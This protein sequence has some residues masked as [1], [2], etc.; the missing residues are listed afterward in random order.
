MN[1]TLN[2]IDEH[3]T[4]MHT[5]RHSIVGADRRGYNDSSSEYSTHV[6]HRLSYINGQETDEEE[7]QNQHTRKE[8]MSWSPDRVAEYLEEVGVEKKHCDIFREQEISGEVL[9]VMEQDTL[10]LKEL[11]LGPVGRRLRTWH[12]IKALQQDLR[13]PTSMPRS[14]SDFS[15]AG[16]GSND[17]TRNRGSSFGT[18]L[19]RIPSL[20]GVHGSSSMGRSLPQRASTQIP[21]VKEEHTLPLATTASRPPLEDPRPS[22]ASVRS[23]NHSRRHSSFEYVGSISSSAF[24]EAGKSLSPSQASHKKQPSF[25]RGWTMVGS[26]TQ[27]NGQPA[28]T[29]DDASLGLDTTMPDSNPR[30][31]D[32]TVVNALE[33]DRG[34][35]SGGE[36]ENRKSRQLLRKKDS[37]H[38]SAH[39][40]ISTEVKR[41]TAI[42]SRAS[43]P[44]SSGSIRD[45]MGPVVSPAAKA[46]Y[47]TS[48]KKD[49]RT[50]SGPEFG[51]KL[52]TAAELSPTVTKLDY[53]DSPS[54][55]TI[56]LSPSVAGSDTSS[57]GLNSPVMQKTPKSI[58]PLTS[59]SFG[60]RAISDAIT[61]NEKSLA[62]QTGDA[63][64]PQSKDSPLQSPGSSTPSATSKSFEGDSN[65][66]KT[67]TSA[68][69]TI[70]SNGTTRR[71]SK[72]H[73]SAYTRGL[74]KRSPAEQMVGCDYSGWMKKRSSN[75]MTTWKTRLFVLRG[76]RLSYYY[77]EKDTEERGLIDISS[78]RVLPAD[79]ERITG[80]HASL[81][82]AAS[83]PTSPQYT[84]GPAIANSFIAAIAPDP[85]PNDT[86]IFI[87]KLVP[88]RSGLSKAVNFTKPTVH[89][90]AVDNVQQGRL[91]MA[92]LMKATIDRD[93][94]TPVVTTYQQKTIS[95]AKA[96]AT[97]Q[98][99]P[100]LMNVDEEANQA[101]DGEVKD[102]T[103]LAISGLSNSAPP[104]SHNDPTGERENGVADAERNGLEEKRRV[105]SDVPSAAAVSLPGSTASRL[106]DVDSKDIAT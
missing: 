73:T 101:G 23:I 81:T 47:S 106:S 90:F 18:V 13:S 83:S 14:M 104:E 60:L 69:G 26:Q 61:G 98:R 78:H 56:A 24:S 33:L 70:S 46:Y 72:K 67:P 103:G 94:S 71:K 25:D 54:I 87:F 16:D 41:R 17:L 5:P 53:T 86:G 62:L 88:P 37:A 35:F 85:K 51:R 45:S 11:D 4:D 38:H 80:L 95:L 9:L 1:E 76:C 20:S 49:R 21:E 97:K 99:P 52:H 66:S 93:E 40:S 55:D 32:M 19:P 75:L 58:Q 31:L 105:A 28:S 74:E 8:V 42:Q 57:L 84:L 68:G 15:N 63:L 36:L 50:A 65:A 30:E 82:R 91:W 43:R 96:K 6:D 39:S 64:S 10:F 22:A 89:Y 2:V 92:A 77:S 7:E 48:P 34:Y 12:K 44:E 100:A 102:E 29:M 79:N 3:I 59:R 27:P